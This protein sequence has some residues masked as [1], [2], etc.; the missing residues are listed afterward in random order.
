MLN[1]IKKKSDFTF[2]NNNNKNIKNNIEANNNILDH[3]F[4]FYTKKKI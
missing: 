1:N 4:K 2:H 3:Y